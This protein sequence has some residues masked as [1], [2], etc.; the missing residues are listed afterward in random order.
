MGHLYQS[1]AAFD[2][3][4]REPVALFRAIAASGFKVLCVF[5]KRQ[6]CGHF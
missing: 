6:S 3:F 4:L 5:E 1:S 2:I